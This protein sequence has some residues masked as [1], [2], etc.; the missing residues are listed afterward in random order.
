[1]ITA[2]SISIDIGSNTT[3]SGYR[4]NVTADT[5]VAI[6]TVRNVEIQSNISN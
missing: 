2:E 4:G 6:K 3:K 5:Q 1:M